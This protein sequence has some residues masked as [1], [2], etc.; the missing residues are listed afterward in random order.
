MTDLKGL[1]KPLVWQQC[2]TDCLRVNTVF[3]RYEVMWGKGLDGTFLDIAGKLLKHDT[4]EAAK[5][6]AQADY[7]ARIL[8]A[9][10]LAKVEALVGAAEVALT[11][12]YYV[13]G[14]NDCSRGID[15]LDAAL[16]AMKGGDT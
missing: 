14:E 16:A 11:V 3:G 10:D 9:L 6:A 1:V 12:M 8:A 13:D 4:L 5:A 15:A 7:E 2:G